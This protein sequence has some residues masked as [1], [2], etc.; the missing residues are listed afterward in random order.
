MR[1]LLIACLV[2]LPASV[3]APASAG[4]ATQIG[5]TLTPTGTCSAGYTWLQSQYSSPADGVITRWDYQAD[6]SNIPQLKFK[7]GRLVTGTTY[8]IVGESGVVSPVPSTLNHFPVRIP[9]K[10]GDLIGFY[11]VTAG[12]CDTPNASFTELYANADVA[13]GAQA[14]FS[15]LNYQMDV[16]ASLE[17]DADHD[18]YGDETQDKCVGTP[19]AFNGCP[20]TV[21]LNRLRQ[22]GT[23]AKVKVRATVP[24][25][26]TIKAGTPSDPA[27]ASASAKSL[28]LVS[29]T[30]TSTSTQQ[31]VLTLKLTKSAKRKLAARGKLKVKVKVI[32]TPLGGP[33]GSQTGKV[34]LVKKH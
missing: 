32:Y 25:A 24:G 29:Q 1:R 30:L 9:V 19:G 34:K 11:T 5:N 10:A 28:R 20:N 18:G 12:G 17:P 6:A 7:V 26:G 16:S 21:T 15:P 22:K 31:V 27:L 14:T 33:S 3:A 4:A 8:S 13:P 23:K 2:A